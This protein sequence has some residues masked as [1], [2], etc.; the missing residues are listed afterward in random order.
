MRRKPYLSLLLALVILGG[1]LALFPTLWMLLL[2]VLLGLIT[3]QAIVVRRNLYRLPPGHSQVFYPTPRGAAPGQAAAAPG[4]PATE[5]VTPPGP[6]GAGSTAATPVGPGGPADAPAA[7]V[8]G[9]PGPAPDLARAEPAAPQAPPAPASAPASAP[10]EPAGAARPNIDTA[11][12]SRFRKHLEQAEAEASGQAAPREVP[13]DPAEVEDRVELSGAARRNAPARRPPAAPPARAQAR[14]P[15]AA[16]P[17]GRPAP[18]A[19]PAEPEGADLFEDLRPVPPSAP[20]APGPPPAAPAGSAH[21]P[22][23]APPPPPRPPPEPARGA[24]PR[25]VPGDEVSAALAQGPGDAPGLA[26]EAAAVLHLAEEAAAR[27]DWDGLRAGLDNYLAH[28][29][30]APALVHWRA[31]RLQARLAVHEGDSNRALQGFEE[32]LAAGHRPRVEEVPALLDGLL[33]GAERDTAASLRVS[34]LVR[35]LA[36]FR[37]TRDQRAMDQCYGWIEEAQEQVGDERRLLQYLR[38][39]LEIRKVLGD[40]PGQLELIDQLGNRC[41][42]LGLTEEAKAYYEM[43]L[44]LRAEAGQDAAQPARP[45]GSAPEG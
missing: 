16:T 1:M 19:Q 44:R 20:P 21:A 45:P 27:E 25:A 42:R 29:A 31:R 28:L 3:V 6:A 37:Q 26:D 11:L 5:G 7:P 34:M 4:P 8:A 22:A 23:G 2:I 41:Y 24:G 35:I 15:P 40:V 10:T 43:G 32:L 30:D 38:N 17:P 12:F 18:A 39:H 36:G 9:A 13:V 14:T 33:A